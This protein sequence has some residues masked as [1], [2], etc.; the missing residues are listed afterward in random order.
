MIQHKGA[1]LA[2]FNIENY[3]I[4]LQNGCIYVDEQPLIFYH[5]HGLSEINDWIYD[6]NY[7]CHKARMTQII[8]NNIYKKYIMILK[9]L[10]YEINL[11]FDVRRSNVRKYTSARFG[12]LYDLLPDFVVDTLMTLKTLFRV[13]YTNTGIFNFN[14]NANVNLEKYDF[15]KK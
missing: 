13:L 14:S 10:Q 9:K 12:F 5:F 6:S 7:S 3:L 4:S 8:R 2:S 15:Y 11:Q 1:N